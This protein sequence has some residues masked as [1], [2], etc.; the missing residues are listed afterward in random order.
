MRLNKPKTYVGLSAALVLM[1]FSTQA[2]VAQNFT[3]AGQGWST[4]WGFSSASDRSLAM[5]QAQAIRQAKT[6][7]GPTTVVNTYNTTSNDNRS[8]Y[9]EILGTSMTFDSIDFQ[10]NGDRIGQNT[11]TIG[12]MNTGTTNIDIVGSGNNVIATNSAETDGCIDGSIQ[13]ETTTFEPASSPSGIDISIS[14]TGRT[15]A[16]SP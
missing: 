3:S 11:N 8:S 12:S 5:Q 13:L 6:Q 1:C 4:G 10:L 9:Q 15:M 7:A 16:C 14:P 2:L